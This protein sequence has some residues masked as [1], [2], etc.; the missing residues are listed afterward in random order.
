M[1]RHKGKSRTFAHNIRLAGILSFIAG[2]VNIS[3]VLSVKT[4]T[5]NVTGHFAF[6]AEEFMKKNYSN[7]FIF[8][9]YILFFLLGAFISNLLIEIEL[10]RRPK[11][12][13]AAPMMIEI[14]ILIMVGFFGKRAELFDSSGQFI[15]CV[16][17]FAMGIQNSL[18]TQISD[19]KV[20]TTHLTGLF[21]DLGIELSQLFFYKEINEK[22][23][24]TRSIYLLLIIIA[25]FFT[26]CVI[27]GYLFE[28]FELKTL[29]F[30]A[31]FLIIAFFYDNIL[32]QFYYV[33]RKLQDR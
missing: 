20:R 24:L 27:G 8:L 7:A 19:A 25:F 32:Y 3:G 18:V 23:R 26:G 10:R 33:K 21:T 30:A 31:V 4:L 28:V 17:L 1:F 14:L 9:F 15:A 6:F 16:L 13:H 29:L 12:A 2:M 5:T 22:K 11:T